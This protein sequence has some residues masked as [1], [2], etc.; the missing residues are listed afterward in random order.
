ML[1]TLIGANPV[2]ARPLGGKK[3]RKISDLLADFFDRNLDQAG[4]VEAA[5]ENDEEEDAA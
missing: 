3:A 1:R 5:N 2:E 4:E